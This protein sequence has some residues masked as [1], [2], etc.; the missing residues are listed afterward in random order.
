MRQESSVLLE[1]HLTRHFA[2]TVVRYIFYLSIFIVFAVTVGIIHQRNED[3]PPLMIR[4]YDPATRTLITERI[5]IQWSAVK[6][7]SLRQDNPTAAKDLCNYHKYGLGAVDY[8][9]LAFL[10]YFRRDHPNYNRIFRTLNETLDPSGVWEE[11]YHSRQADAAESPAQS[12]IVFADLYSHARNLS[13]IAVRGTDPNDN[14]DLLQDCMLFIEAAVYQVVSVVFPGMSQ[15]PRDLIAQVIG[16]TARVTTLAD[17]A[18]MY[19][20]VPL[21]NYVRVAK[22]SRAVVVVGHSLG[23]ALAKIAG[24]HNNVPVVAISSPGIALS[25]KKFALSLPVAHA[26]VTNIMPQYDAIASLDTLEGSILTVPCSYR[27]P[28]VCHLLEHTIATLWQEC[29]ENIQRKSLW[30]NVSVLAPPTSW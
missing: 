13:V 25:S 24:I 23:G 26:R 10:V 6:P 28:D 1:D 20:W 4:D 16:V 9:W 30:T 5:R 17:P 21:S 7:A 27:R 29:R 11:Y 19:Y 18:A 2:I 15:L 12:H 3:A 22:K 14:M 8:A